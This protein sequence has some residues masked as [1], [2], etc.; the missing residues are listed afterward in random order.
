MDVVLFDQQD[1]SGFQVVGFSF[2]EVGYV[3]GQEEDYFVEVVVMEVEIA[4]NLVFYV[5]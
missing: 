1:V 5:E 4:L 2:D 3:A